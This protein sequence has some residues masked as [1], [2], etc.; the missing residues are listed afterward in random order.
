MSEEW[1]PWTDHDGSGCPCVG[2]RVRV[3]VDTDVRASLGRNDSRISF[4]EWETIA[5]PG[6]G[7]DWT[8]GYVHIV[9]YRLWRPKALRDLIDIACKPKRMTE[10]V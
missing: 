6:H 9:R 5:E 2:Q 7:W 10:D 4:F 8:P 3:I 1:G